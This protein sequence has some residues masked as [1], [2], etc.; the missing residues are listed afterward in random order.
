M[1]ALEAGEGGHK[2]E[3]LADYLVKFWRPGQITWAF[4]SPGQITWPP[5]FGG[6][7]YLGRPKGG[8]EYLGRIFAKRRGRYLGGQLPGPRPKAGQTTCL[9]VFRSVATQ[10]PNRTKPVL[11]VFLRAAWPGMTNGRGKGRRGPGSA[12]Y[13]NERRDKNGLLYR[14][15]ARAGG[16]QPQHPSG[17]TTLGERLVQQSQ[18]ALAMQRLAEQKLKDVKEMEEINQEWNASLQVKHNFLAKV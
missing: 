6:A 7:D 13:A 5:Q 2:L 10:A 4:N 8:A 1:H 15:K 11:G 9:H 16:V 12:A 14:D 3:F 18:K 17:T